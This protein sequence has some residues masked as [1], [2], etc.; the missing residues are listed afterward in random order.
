MVPRDMCGDLF[1][2]AKKLG[3]TRTIGKPR[4]KRKAPADFWREKYLNG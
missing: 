3:M 4:Q 2:V 1:A